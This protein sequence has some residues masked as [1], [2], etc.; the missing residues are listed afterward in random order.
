MTKQTET[1]IFSVKEM[2]QLLEDLENYFTQE[3]PSTEESRL[4]FRSLETLRFFGRESNRLKAEA[5]KELKEAEKRLTEIIGAWFVDIHQV[6]EEKRL[7][8]QKVQEA[9]ERPDLDTMEW[10]KGWKGL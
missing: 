8:I 5:A 1:P 3:G 10:L 2:N 9:I 7:K 4:L 6:V